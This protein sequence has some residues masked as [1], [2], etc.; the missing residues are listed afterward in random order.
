MPHI[1]RSSL[2]MYSTQQMYDLV[3]DIESYSEFLPGCSGGSILKRD[4]EWVDA[5]LELAK[6]GLSHTFSTRNRMVAGDT[7]E[8][9]LLEGPFRHLK[10]VWV[11]KALGDAGCKVSLELDFEMSSALAQMTIGAVF[12]QMVNKMVEAFAQRAKQ[13]YG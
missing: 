9:Y 8:M 2:V 11:F 3:S 5:S 4:G 7:I 10:G 13:V 6:G 12:G 1:S